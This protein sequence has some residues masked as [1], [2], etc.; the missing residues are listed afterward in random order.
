M[1]KELKTNI[2]LKFLHLI[3]H[4]GTIFQL[5][6]PL[7]VYPSH[8]ILTSFSCP[9]NKLIELIDKM[10]RNKEL[11]VILHATGNTKYFY[12]LKEDLLKKF[13]KFYI[14]LHVSPKHFL[15][16]NRMNEIVEL[17]KLTQKYNLKILVASKELKKEYSHYSLNA[18]PIQVG[19]NFDKSRLN[20]I[21][22]QPKKYI[23]T[24]C[25]SEDRIYNYIKGIDLFCSLMKG[26]NLK[27]EAV[28]L[29]NISNIFKEIKSKKV[30]QM[31]FL[32]YLSNSKVYIQLSRTEAYNLSAVYAKRLKIPIIV[33]NTEGHKDNVKYGFRVK[34]L[35]EAKL[36]LKKILSNPKSPKIKKAIEKNYQDSLKREN[37][38]NFRNLL[39]KLWQVGYTTK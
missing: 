24:V 17:R 39:N 28:V 3:D 13:N 7:T 10:S 37:L 11:I 22:K 4:N 29:G 8:K 1:N 34:N 15:I 20:L 32:R 2:P 33:S 35:N 16:K 14:F 12:N 30:S 36:I 25:T 6:S 31:N 23:T 26:L 9:E 19:I 5:I 18:I 38:N 27:K 21:K